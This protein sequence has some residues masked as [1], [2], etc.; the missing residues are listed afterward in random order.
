[1][2]PP[3]LSE[4][5]AKLL[6]KGYSAR[7]TDEDT[8]LA[9]LEIIDK[10]FESTNEGHKLAKDSFSETRMTSPPSGRCSCCGR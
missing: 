9:E 5:K 4:V 2:L 3:K 10:A 6:T 1:M 8:L 7:S